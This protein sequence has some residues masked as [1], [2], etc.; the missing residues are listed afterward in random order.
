MKYDYNILQTA[1]IIRKAAEALIQLL[2][3]RTDVLDVDDPFPLI[4]VAKRAQKRLRK[5]TDI[6]QDKTLSD[7][8]SHIFQISTPSRVHKVQTLISKTFNPS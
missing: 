3:R 8:E 2:T 4:A 7:P 1:G 6:T 5:V